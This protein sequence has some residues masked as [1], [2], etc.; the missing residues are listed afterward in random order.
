MF[1]GQPKIHY[2]YKGRPQ[3]I[4]VFKGQPKFRYV[5]KYKNI[6]IYFYEFIKFNKNW[7]IIR[8]HQSA[9]YAR[10]SGNIV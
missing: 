10:I 8:K 4:Y 2:V 9:N 5:Y 3:I 6:K 1:K 7:F